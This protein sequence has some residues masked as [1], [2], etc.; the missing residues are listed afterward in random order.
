MSRKRQNITLPAD[1]I[2]DVRIFANAKIVYAVL[3]TFP[4]NKVKADSPSSLSFAASV[5]A[6]TITHSAIIERSGL[7]RHTVVKSLN[8]LETAGWII[9][10][11]S[12]GSANKYYFTAPVV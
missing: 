1:L 8:K 11:R 7:S 10:E 9:Q 5:P 2:L 6:V 4:K 12:P 3:K